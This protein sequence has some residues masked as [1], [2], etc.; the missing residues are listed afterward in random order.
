MRHTHKFIVRW[1][2]KGGPPVD[3]FHKNFV[4][5][6][7][8]DS[9]PHSRP[10]NAVNWIKRRVSLSASPI[11][12]SLATDDEER[13]QHSLL[14]SPNITSQQQS[15]HEF[16]AATH[17]SASPFH[18]LNSAPRQTNSPQG[19]PAQMMM[20]H[21][22]IDPSSPLSI[23]AATS[24]LTTFPYGELQALNARMNIEAAKKNPVSLKGINGTH[25]VNGVIG[26]FDVDENSITV[27]KPAPKQRS[28]TTRERN[29]STTGSAI[30]KNLLP[31]ALPAPIPAL[32]GPDIDTIQLSSPDYSPSPAKRQHVKQRNVSTSALLRSRPAPISHK[33]S[34]SLSSTQNTRSSKRLK[35]SHPIPL[36]PVTP[37]PPKSMPPPVKPKAAQAKVTT[38][39]TAP[40]GKKRVLPVRQGHIDILDGEISLLSTPQRLD[41]KS[42][43]TSNLTH[44]PSIFRNFPQSHLSR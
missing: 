29:V 16:A 43:L 4:Q 18:R 37:P 30:S 23:L 20:Q 6:S 12:P 8:L 31:S 11:L 26:N 44:R 33:R 13:Q 17:G 39:D 25:G 41:S 19:T 35:T 3:A 9:A 28:R 34:A 7:T 42:Y 27:A 22:I 36:S 2:A 24:K 5:C 21:D 14:L 15:V 40:T 1:E 10:M 32:P 38:T